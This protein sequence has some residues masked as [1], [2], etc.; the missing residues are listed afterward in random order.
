M[1]TWAD[2]RGQETARLADELATV[3]AKL[4]AAIADAPWYGRWSVRALY[5]ACRVWA[6]VRRQI[7]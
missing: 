6:R 1:T 2:Y 5:W 7:E 4:N 3:Q